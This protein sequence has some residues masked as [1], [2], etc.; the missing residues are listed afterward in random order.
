[1]TE[2]IIPLSPHLYH[3]FLLVAKIHNQL[4]DDLIIEA[5]ENGIDTSLRRI[6]RENNVPTDEAKMEKRLKA[7]LLLQERE[8]NTDDFE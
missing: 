8:H 2:P 5:L 6:A 7:L 4:V 3:Q 1:M